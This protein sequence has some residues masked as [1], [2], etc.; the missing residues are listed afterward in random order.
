MIALLFFVVGVPLINVAKLYFVKWLDS[1]PEKLTAEETKHV[2]KD[3]E[4]YGGKTEMTEM[5][6]MISPTTQSDAALTNTDELLVFVME[7]MEHVRNHGCDNDL[8]WTKFGNEDWKRW[9]QIHSQKST[10]STPSNLECND[11][12]TAYKKIHDDKLWHKSVKIIFNMGNLFF[13]NTGELVDKFHKTLHILEKIMHGG[14]NMEDNVTETDLCLKLNFGNPVV[15]AMLWSSEPPCIRTNIYSKIPVPE[16]IY[17]F[18]YS[19]LFEKISLYIGLI[20]ETISYYVDF[21]ADISI[22]ILFCT[23]TYQFWNSFSSFVE[24][25]AA[26]LTMVI[27]IPEIMKSFYYYANRPFF[28]DTKTSLNGRGRG[29]VALFM[30]GWGPL[31][32]NILFFERFKIQKD[33]FTR[34]RGL[35]VHINA[36]LKRREAKSLAERKIPD[37]AEL[38]RINSEL[39]EYYK[40]VDKRFEYYRIMT[41]SQHLEANTET[42]YQYIAYL[43]III[44]SHVT[45]AYL[46][47]S[48]LESSIQKES[49]YRVFYDYPTGAFLLFFKVAK[50]FISMIGS[51]VGIEKSMKN[52]AFGD[53]AKIFFG[54]YTLFSL[55]AKLFSVVMY[56]VPALGLFGFATHKWMSQMRFSESSCIGD[57]RNESWNKITREFELGK[58]YSLDAYFASYVLVVIP[59]TSLLLYVAKTYL[60]TKSFGGGGIKRVPRKLMHIAN[61]VIFPSI[62]Q[63]WDEDFSTMN[64]T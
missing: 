40:L 53:N 37:K 5:K 25:L 45:I 61:C 63:D 47:N 24:Y 13:E 60:F 27:I 32:S 28:I 48:A 21:V 51:R 7:I 12:L 20:G 59:F 19:T 46:N 9:K 62:T 23:V 43:I 14:D 3:L 52:G 1:A 8:D 64:S 58:H 30:F 38:E 49:L 34:R 57:N 56:F 15:Y 22:L 54:T 17:K 26:T 4:E 10:D 35:F 2:D 42:F 39:T 33:L 44:V 36:E 55:F 41:T 6:T 29:V 50:T 11:L 16:K 31:L 18:Y